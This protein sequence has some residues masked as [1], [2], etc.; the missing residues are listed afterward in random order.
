MIH[1]NGEKIL[2]TRTKYRF[3]HH[4][5]RFL[6]VFNHL[7]KYERKSHLIPNLISHIVHK[8]LMDK[9]RHKRWRQDSDFLTLT[10]VLEQSI[11]F[12]V[13]LGFK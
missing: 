12:N 1:C 8:R 13:Q 6:K 11:V 4:P 7:G 9:E 2:Q 3:C 10:I 5:S